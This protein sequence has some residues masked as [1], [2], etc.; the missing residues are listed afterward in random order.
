M[1]EDERLRFVRGV[2]KVLDRGTKY[3]H[4][5]LGMA[6][7]Y[8]ANAAE[9]TAK[10]ACL[11]VMVAMPPKLSSWLGG[12][13]NGTAL[14]LPG[15]QLCPLLRRNIEP[16]HSN[17][18]ADTFSVFLRVFFPVGLFLFFVFG[19]ESLGSDKGSILGPRSI[20]LHR[21]SVGVT[22]L[23]L[24]RLDTNE[25]LVNWGNRMRC[26]GRHARNFLR[27]RYCLDACNIRRPHFTIRDQ[28][29][30]REYSHAQ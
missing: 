26:W 8:I 28:A 7:H 4:V 22:I 20:F 30:T 12:S 18:V 29:R 16:L 21:I 9:N 19:P 10:P 24:A 2:D 27:V 13:A 23:F 5:V 25:T 6:Q 14:A 3:I 1:P 11:M 15:K 17:T